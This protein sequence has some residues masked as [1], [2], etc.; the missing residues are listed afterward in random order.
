[1]LPV[2]PRP[3]A[4]DPFGFEQAIDRLGKGIVVGA[5]NASDRRL[6]ASLKPPAQLPI[7]NTPSS[8]NGA[9]N[10]NK[11]CHITVNPVDGIAGH[12]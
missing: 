12:S 4:I 8:S 10:R 2:A 1:M 6:D 9:S 11:P 3:L 7:A 5:A